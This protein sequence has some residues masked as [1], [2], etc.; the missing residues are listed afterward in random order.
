MIQVKWSAGCGFFKVADAQKVYEELLDMGASIES[1]Q[2]SEIVDRA[3]DESLEMHK[4]FEWDDAKAGHE[5]RKVQARNMCRCLVIKE[6]E[7]PK[8]RPE[9]RVLINTKRTDGYKPLEVVLRN[10]DEYQK[11]LARAWNE[12]RSFKVKYEMLENDLKEIF[13][14]IS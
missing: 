9:I 5:W 12:L 4:C 14:L 10:E 11:L 3:R 1:L 2:P 8:D 7:V 6:P 13:D